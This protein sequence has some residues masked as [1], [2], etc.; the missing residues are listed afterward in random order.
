M[1]P[2][3]DGLNE[4]DGIFS[5]KVIIL[6]NNYK[7]YLEIQRPLIFRCQSYGHRIFK[8]FDLNEVFPKLA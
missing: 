2:F 7:H 4:V 6:P 5:S 8:L 3:Y 1:R